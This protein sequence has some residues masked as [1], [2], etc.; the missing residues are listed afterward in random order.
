M[1]TPPLS[2][3]QRIDLEEE[4]SGANV[5]AAKRT[6]RNFLLMSVLFSANHASVVACLALATVRLGSIGAWQSGVLYLTYTGSA[7]FGATYFVKKLGSRDALIAG[8]GLYCAYVACFSVATAW[9]EHERSIAMIGA[10]IGGI[11]AGFL[12]TAQGAYFSK[13]SEDHA[14]FSAQPTSQSTSYL[15]GIFAFIYLT[16]EVCLKALSSMAI[17]IGSVTWSTIFATYALITLV[18]T[19]LMSFVYKYPTITPPVDVSGWYKMTAAARL[20]WNDPKMKY[21][22][23]LNAS[24][25]FASAFLNSYV[26]SEVVRTVLNDTNSQYVGYL[27]A[28]LSAVAAVMSLI[29]GRLSSRY[30]KGPI[31]ILGPCCFFWVAFSFVLRP[32]LANWSGPMLVMIYTLHGIGRATFEGTLKATFADYFP[33]EKEG[34]FAN[35]ILQNGLSSAIGYVLTFNLHCSDPT[36]TYCAEFKDGS[37]HNVLIFEMIV[38]VSSIAAVFGYWRASSLYRYSFLLLDETTQN[39]ELVA[40][41]NAEFS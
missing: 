32:E 36:K 4:T 5:Q 27:T 34:A 29:F 20:L 9:K 24:F 28:W 16:A 41:E 40:N 12:W 1:T 39:S 15:G 21:M 6:L 7:V 35:I 25:G 38:A 3:Y 17:E 33:Q 11:G 2:T 18:T 31:L 10:A 23:G 22:I 14:F 19:F 30:G 13:A 37:F 26:N 8:M